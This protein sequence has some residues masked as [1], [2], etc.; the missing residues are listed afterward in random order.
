MNSKIST[1]MNSILKTPT[2]IPTSRDKQRSAKK[3]PV[4]QDKKINGQHKHGLSCVRTT[5]TWLMLCTD[6][7]AFVFPFCTSSTNLF[8]ALNFR[9]TQS[10]TRK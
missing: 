7:T 9:A 2:G 8:W 10:L 6:N 3:H 4:Y 5:Q 1:N